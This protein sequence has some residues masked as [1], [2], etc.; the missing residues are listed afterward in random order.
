M[1]GV[2]EAL[3]AD[4]PLP[5][6]GLASSFL[7]AFDDRR[8]R[9]GQRDP[10]LPALGEV[11]DTFFE[12]E[13]VET[14]ALL[15]A[16]AG[17][18]GDDVLRHRV[19]RELGAR[20][21]VL[22][23]WLVALDEAR[24]ADRVVQMRHVLGDGDNL[25]VGIRLPGGPELTAVVYIDH[26]LGSLV[27][28]AFVL[29]AGVVEVVELM[30]RT[31]DDPDVAFTDP[32]PADA[33]ARIE[34]AIQIWSMTVPPLESDTWPACRAV[35]EWACSLLPAGGT[36]YERPEW[37][38]EE[39]TALGRRF[40]DSP[41]GAGL[42][43]EDHHGLLE[44]LLWFGSGYG[45]GDPLHWSPVS[46]EIL[47]VDWIP[48]KIVA[49]APYLAKAPELL[50]AFVRFCHAERGIR[51]ELTAE[52]LAAVDEYEPQYQQTIRTPRPQGPEAL[53]VA[54]GALDAAG[55]WPA[56]PGAD[57]DVEAIGRDR[58]A[59]AVGGFEA[60]EELDDVPLPDEPFRWEAVPADLHE[61]VA[62]VLGLV[63]RC[64]A[65]LLDVELRTAGR[66][67]LARVAADGPGV[68]RRRSAPAMS[69]AAI[70]WVVGKANH[71]FPYG[72]LTVKDLMSWCGLPGRSPSQRARVFLQVLGVDPDGFTYGGGA[73]GSPDYLTGARR[74]RIIAARDGG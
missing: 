49:D 42:D 19:R 20:G 59:E 38:D 69:A 74:H 5:L 48:R 11:V 35:V 37:T 73:L 9:F 61:R 51:A 68:L 45:P 46:V 70:C 13:L 43:D 27:K 18:G 53:L 65:E 34:E 47:L 3:A 30:R 7:A 14:S 6:L 29:P 32:P 31:A 41:F 55:P 57:D 56:V 40:F 66:R 8:S 22:P 63:D 28:D 60:L 52:T 24:P 10:E 33:R 62:E 16:I 39:L 72:R 12:V 23:R 21:H 17:L 25:L 44:S 15:A 26:N 1:A 67:L 2:A 50:R 58:L 64:C 54:M 71:V 4:E 36:G